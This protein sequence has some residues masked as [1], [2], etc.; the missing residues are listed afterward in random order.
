M[1]RRVYR[2]LDRPATFFG[3][4]GRFIIVMVAGAALAAFVG[5]IV[6]GC[7]SMLMGFGVVLVLVIVAYFLTTTL[8]SRID[9]KDIWKTVV[10]KAYPACYRVRQKHIRNI[11]R[12]FNL[13]NSHFI[14]D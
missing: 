11:W 5:I 9:E 6:G 1:R 2:S 10:K 12:G 7:T 13:A 3:I 4:R 14:K 8:Q